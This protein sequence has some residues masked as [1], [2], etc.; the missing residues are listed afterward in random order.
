MG[1]PVNKRQKQMHRKRVND[2]AEANAPPKVL[3]KNHVSSPAHSTYGGKSLAAIGLGTGSISSTPSA[4]GAP[5][6]AKSVSD[7]DPLSY[8]KPQPYP[9]QDIAQSSRGTATEIPAE[10]VSTTEVNVQL[11]VGSLESGK[12]T[13]VPSV[14]RSPGGIYQPRWGVTNDCRLDTSDACQ[15]MVDHIVPPGC[16]SELR[17]LPNADFL[18]Q[19]LKKTKAQV[20]RR[21]QRIQVRE[22]EIKKL[23]LEIKSLKVVETEVHNLRNQAKNLETLLE[24]EF[25]DLQVSNNRLSEQVSTLQTQVTG[26]EMIKAAFEEFKKYED[27]KVEQRRG[28]SEGLKYG[29]EHGKASRV[30]ADIEAYDLEA[31]SKLVKTLQDLK[32]LKYPMM[33]QLERLKDAPMELIMASLHLESDTREDAPQWIRDL[34]PSSSQLKIPVYPEVRDPKDPWSVKEEMLLEDAIAANISRA[35]KK[36]KCRVVC[37]THGIGSAHH[38]RSDGILVSAPTVPQGLAILLADA[39]TQTEVADKEEEPHPRLQRSI[40]LPHVYNL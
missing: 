8:A 26:E 3:R 25:T 28:M 24:A 36:K 16:F 30:L 37:R 32:D 11:S 40:S 5:T 4:Q 7:P 12:S 9:E 34:R 19:L 35:E 13:F 23:D 27:D 14:V 6:V 17:H 38:A 2:E 15:D 31:N 18:S 21:D 22:E 39:A 33:D 20:A 10:H 1:P 29:V